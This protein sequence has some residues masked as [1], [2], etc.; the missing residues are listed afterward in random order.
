MSDPISE[1]AAGSELQTAP[2]LLSE[3][4]RLR[5]EDGNPTLEALARR[6]GVSKS[7]LSDNFSGRR[8]VSERTLQAVAHAFGVDAAPLLELRRASDPTPVADPE[9]VTAPPRR[10]FGLGVLVV[11]AVAGLIVGGAAGALGAATLG[12]SSAAKAAPRATS[13]DVG[14]AAQISVKTGTDPAQTKCVNDAKV[15]VSQNGPHDM[16]LQIV[17][18]AACHAAW[19]RIGRYDNAATGNE[20]STSIY[21]SIAPDAKD[22]QSTTEPDAQSAYTTLI[23]RPTPQTEICAVGS[24]TLN[25]VTQD[26]GKPVCM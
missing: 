9:P 11:V 15:V 4:R 16:Q 22:R 12:G 19:S 13:A 1:P 17:Y 6:T 7:I 26:F 10:R 3:L 2:D 8:P 20:V 23:I 21:R 14:T 25:G 5:N 24:D 18:S